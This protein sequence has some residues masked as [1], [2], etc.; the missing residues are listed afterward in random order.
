MAPFLSDIF[1]YSKNKTRILIYSSRSAVAQVA[2]HI[3]KINQ[4]EFDYFL[5]TGIAKKNENDFVILESS[6]ENLCTDFQP[7]IVFISNE[8]KPEQLTS[9]VENIV[10]GGILIYPT[11]MAEIVENSEN[12]FRKLPF[13]LPL[14]I[15]NENQFILNTEIGSIPLLTKDENICENIEGLKFLSQQFGVMEEDFFE[16]IMSF[17]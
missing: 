10:P 7:N 5:E 9:V 17:E 2:L 4:K 15:K 11:Q 13:S 16:A 3:L 6:H 8:V 1:S 12:F 14:F